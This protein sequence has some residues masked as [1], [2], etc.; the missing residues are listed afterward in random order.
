[1]PDHQSQ[2]APAE[3]KFHA[4]NGEDGTA[5]KG[6]GRHIAAFILRASNREGA[7]R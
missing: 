3:N 7:N 1:M 5:G 4:G 2:L 6:T